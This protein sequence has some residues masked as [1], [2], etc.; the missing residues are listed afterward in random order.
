M[1][2]S[3]KVRCRSA[4]LATGLVLLLSPACFQSPKVDP[5][6]MTCQTDDNCLDGYHCVRQIQGP[7]RCQSSGDGDDAG[8]DLGAAVSADGAAVDG[9]TNGAT[10]DG[11]QAIDR[12]GWP[13]G[14]D[15][16]GTTA[17]DGSGVADAVIL[18]IDLGPDL[19]GPD[20]GRDLAAD[21]NTADASI[22]DAPA[23]DLPMDLPAATSDSG[24]AGLKTAGTACGSGAECASTNCVDGVCCSSAC[25]GQCQSCNVSGSEGTCRAV[26]TP[27]HRAACAG[28]GK[29]VGVCDG[30]HGDCQYPGASTSCTTA[31]CTLGVT[32]P[33]ASCDGN[34]ACGAPGPNVACNGPCNAAGTGCGQCTT[35]ADCASVPNTYCASGVC[36]GRKTLGVTCAGDAECSNEH[37]VDGVCCGS[38]CS[39]Q[40]EYCNAS[41]MCVPV[42]ANGAPVGIRAPCAGAG[43][44]CAGKCD[45]TVRTACNY[46]ST[47]VVCTTASCTSGSSV[48]A[49]KCDGAG[50]CPN[51]S[52][53]PC[54]RYQCGT[55][56]CL[57]SCASD[58]DCTTGNYC[59]NPGPSGTCV[60]K[61]LPGTACTVGNS[62]TTGSC[63]P[64]GICC[65]SA[66]TGACESCSSTGSC[67]KKSITT[68]CR[69]AGASSICDPPEYCT[70]T[71]SN[72]PANQYALNGTSCGASASCL[73]GS[74]TAATVCDGSGTC[75]P[76][77][78]TGCGNYVCG[79]TACLTSCNSGSD[80]IST[81]SCVSHVCTDPPTTWQA[82]GGYSPG[83]PG[84]GLATPP[85]GSCTPGTAGV[86]AKVAD[87][88][89][90]VQ[91]ELHR[92]ATQD[93]ACASGSYFYAPG[94]PGSSGTTQPFRQCGTTSPVWTITS[95]SATFGACLPT[96]A[97]PAW[98]ANADSS[99]TTFVVCDTSKTTALQYYVCQ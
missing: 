31:S 80:C 88:P 72:C 59:A 94:P 69:A 68:V 45:G 41:G 67:T 87:I 78:S 40:C 29:C 13:D 93:W 89:A 6:N 52:S 19:L 70:G 25:V 73:S 39:G 64:G 74:Q 37:C 77:Q 33:A 36:T 22:A 8:A 81:K 28:T 51:V 76:G 4:A 82:T 47:D 63:A 38:A 79:A 91:Y 84:Y 95:T 85:S 97:D 43:G 14:V 46:P 18:G 62:C 2:T 54:G 32:T 71:S 12:A 90:G 10:S 49:V 96:T 16:A 44:T 92:D 7:W 53:T 57:S 3:A 9:A 11:A 26:A 1:A 50:Q 17:V 58:N 48:P 21:F 24:G 27:S 66:C 35:N 75:V 34:G 23:A 56:Q 30:Q 60:A 5:N 98:Y 61:T 42:S 83:P 20:L 99:Y 65:D 55:T 86:L 15:S